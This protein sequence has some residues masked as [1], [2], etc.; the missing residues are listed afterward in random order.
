MKITMF[1]HCLKFTAIASS[2][3]ILINPAFAQ[4]AGG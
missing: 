2:F 4:D 3:F 1:S